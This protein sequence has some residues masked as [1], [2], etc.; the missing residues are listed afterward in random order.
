MDNLHSHN[1][2]TWAW[3]CAFFPHPTSRAPSLTHLT[4]KPCMCS[5]HLSLIPR[6]GLVGSVAATHG[7]EYS[8]E[9]VFIATS[10]CSGMETT[11]HL[12]TLHP[13]PPLLT[14][15]I[16]NIYR[17]GG[18][19]GGNWASD[20]QLR[21]G[22]FGDVYK[23]VSPRNG[24]TLWAVK[25]AKLLEAD[26]QREP[27]L[28]ILIGAARGFEYLHSFG[29]VHRDIKPANILLGEKMQAK[30]ADFGLVRVEEGTTVGTTRVMGTPGYMDPIYSLTSKATRAIDVYS[31]GVLMLVVLTG[32]SPFGTNEGENVHILAWAF[33]SPMSSFSPPP[34]PI[35]PLFPLFPTPPSLPKPLCVPIAHSQPSSCPP[36]LPCAVSPTASLVLEKGLTLFLSPLSPPSLLPLF[37]LSS[38]ATPFTRF[39][40]HAPSHLPPPH[41]LPP[42]PLPNPTMNPLSANSSAQTAFPQLPSSAPLLLSRATAGSGALQRGPA[43]GQGTGLTPPTLPH[44]PPFFSLPARQG[45]SSDPPPLRRFSYHELQ[46]AAGGVLQLGGPAAGQGKGFTLP[47]S[48]PSR[49]QQ[50]GKGPPPTRLLCAAS[51]IVS[52][53]RRR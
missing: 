29:L 3:L 35:A 26:F 1:N 39:P 44:S 52:C 48:S 18:Q 41:P 16:Q 30:V 37:C 6:A 23:G 33:P 8:L 49:L 38:H 27:R 50:R 9:E 42:R 12:S 10:N 28:D 2:G 25:H 32:R 21:S 4:S 45:P 14:L 13:T 51:P 24:T 31:F 43:A 15:F 22:A 53:S 46:Q 7:T 19:R 47:L 20:N 11:N 5:V 36:P 40:K 34:P 17:P